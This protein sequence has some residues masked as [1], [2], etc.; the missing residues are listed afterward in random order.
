MNKHDKRVLI[1]ITIVSLICTFL[2]F[3]ELPN[4]AMNIDGKRV[5]FDEA[6]HEINLTGAD[7]RIAESIESNNPVIK[8]ELTIVDNKVS[9]I[10]TNYY[11]LQDGIAVSS[12][13]DTVYGWGDWGIN[14]GLTSTTIYRGDW[15]NAVSGQADTALSTALG[16]GS[17]ATGL[18]YAVGAALSN[19]TVIGATITAGNADSVVTND[20]ILE[21]TWNSNAV[22]G[23]VADLSGWS[24]YPAS[25]MISHWISKSISTVTNVGYKRSLSYYYGDP[26][27][28]YWTFYEDEYSSSGSMNFSIN[29]TEWGESTNISSDFFTV[30][31]YPTGIPDNIDITGIS[32]PSVYVGDI[33]SNSW[34]I[35]SSA[36]NNNYDE[37]SGYYVLNV[38]F[39]LGLGAMS[40]DVKS[41]TNALGYDAAFP[42][43]TFGGS[44]DTWGL[45]LSDVSSSDLSNLTFYVNVDFYTDEPAVDFMTSLTFGE[46]QEYAHI[47]YQLDTLDEQKFGIDTDGIFQVEEFGEIKT[48][49]YN[50]DFNSAF[51]NYTTNIVPINGTSTISYASG[52]LVKIVVT[53]PI[54]I[55]FDNSDY[56]TNGVSRV[57]VELWA[58]TNSIAFDTGTITNEVE[59]D[60]N[61]S[62]P[63]S[64]FFR[65]TEQEKW[66]G[67]Q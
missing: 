31:P 10:E 7:I 9:I 17:G 27:Y 23:G 16:V 22:G 28:S 18:V 20:R 66:R 29:I 8:T 54:T 3:A 47:W 42:P 62:G 45:D 11:K 49:I 59:F 30:Q 1:F 24:D 33:W 14:F 53:E 15:G 38:W 57:G 5:I 58:G 46:T 67:R 2:V 56:P 36:C 43:P 65:R 48:P 44:N 50:S 51:Q 52:S 35:Q 63:T 19:E 64:L 21:I 32:W 34:G 12:K 55:T 4:N 40:S 37:V 60:I 6:T 25:N 39:E 61:E 41:V 13:T 26:P